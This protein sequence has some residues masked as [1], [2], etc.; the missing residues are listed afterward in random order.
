MRDFTKPDMTQAL[1]SYATVAQAIAKLF[2][3][4]AEVIVHD[5]STGRI[6]HIYN[7]F[8]KRRVG[9]DSMTEIDDQISLDRD[10]IGPYPKVNWD[11]RE[12]RSV[13]AVLRD[14]SGR[15]IG[16]LCINFDVSVFDGMAALAA[17]FLRNVETEVQPDIL[18]LSDWKEKANNLIDEFLEHRGLA[19]SG[20]SRDD[21]VELV[22]ALDNAGTFTVR[23]SANYVSELLNMSRATLYKYL[24][25]A[26]TSA[27]TGQDIQI[28][29][30]SGTSR[31]IG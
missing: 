28:S 10:V 27:V 16:L 8:S 4:H 7:S 3:P 2:H 24:K 31:P 26:K 14:P 19:I 13:T 9:D 11:R 15:P 5:L 17:S 21:T 30:E 25:R 12:L 29:A 18:F 23:N 6:A 20:L 22:G 1:G